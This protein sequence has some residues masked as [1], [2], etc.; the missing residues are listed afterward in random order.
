MLSDAGHFKR[1][2]IHKRLVP[3]VWRQLEML[4]LRA[5]RTASVEGGT[6]QH[7]LWILAKRMKS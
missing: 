7:C 6:Q 3:S 4:L 5:E 2:E 1:V